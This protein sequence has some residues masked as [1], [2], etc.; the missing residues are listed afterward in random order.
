M[1]VEFENWKLFS[2]TTKERS[3]ILKNRQIRG[4]R[5]HHMSDAF[6]CNF[7]NSLCSFSYSNSEK[8]L[9][10][11]VNS[12]AQDIYATLHPPKPPFTQSMIWA[13]NK[14]LPGHVKIKIINGDINQFENMGDV[15]KAM[16]RMRILYRPP[17]AESQIQ[18]IATWINDR[19]I[20]LSQFTH[21]EIIALTPYLRRFNLYDIDFPLVSTILPQAH[22]VCCLA[23]GNQ[24]DRDIEKY[25]NLLLYPEKLKWLHVSMPEFFLADLPS[26]NQL[27]RLELLD[28]ASCPHAILDGNFHEKI[29]KC[30]TLKDV[31]F[32]KYREYFLEKTIFETKLQINNLECRLSLREFCKSEFDPQTNMIHLSVT[33]PR[34]IDVNYL[35]YFEKYEQVEKITLNM[36]NL[37]ADGLPDLAALFPNLKFVDL[38]GC[39]LIQNAQWEAASLICSS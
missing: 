12:L 38:S 28:L 6:A 22:N 16:Q 19:L 37:T 24:K 33:D 4:H 26:L 5:I 32:C 18:E 35:A 25:L 30:Y 3:T 8:N 31:K 17:L 39:P 9:H 27:V 2:I 34:N 11:Q 23:I 20:P 29:K 7:E 13:F 36:P 21:E 14:G 10:E 15:D 1:N